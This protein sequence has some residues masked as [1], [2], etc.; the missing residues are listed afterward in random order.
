MVESVPAISLSM[1][2]TNPTMVKFWY[3][4]TSS[5]VNSPLE[6]NSSNKEGHSERNKSAPVKDPSPPQTTKASIPLT[7]MFLAACNLP[8]FSLNSI[9]RAV[10]IKVPPRANQPLTS[11]HCI[12]LIKEPPWTKPE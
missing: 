1:E 12:F 4:A 6:T 8:H 11:C 3:G 7:T 5:L 2:P 9:Q 10:P